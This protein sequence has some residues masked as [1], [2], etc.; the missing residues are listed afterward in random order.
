MRQSLVQ[1]YMHIIFSTKNRMRYIKSNW[2][3]EIFR[4]IGSL[5]N[6]KKNVRL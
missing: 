3:P 6:E 2:Q 5:C 4:Y 1:N